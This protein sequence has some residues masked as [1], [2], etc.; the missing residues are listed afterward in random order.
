MT[1]NYYDDIKSRWKSELWDKKVK[2]M[3]IMTSKDKIDKKLKLRDK[4][5]EFG[6]K[7]S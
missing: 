5:L 3:T 4:Q 2:I 1:K 7:K 6:D